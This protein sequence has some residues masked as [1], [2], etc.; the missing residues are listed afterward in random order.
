PVDP[1][2]HL[3]PGK[4]QV[5]EA[6]GDV[7]RHRLPDELVVRLGKQHPDPAAETIPVFAG[8]PFAADED[9]AFGGGQKTG[10]QADE[11]RFARPVPAGEAQPF[12]AFHAQGHAADGRRRGAGTAAGDAAQF[13]NGRTFVCEF[14]HFP[15]RPKSP[16][17]RNSPMRVSVPIRWRAARPTNTPVTTP[18]ARRTG[19]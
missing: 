9:V 2:V 4:A 11:R 10:H 7:V 5:F 1:A 17:S 15:S 6:E 19:K 18:A 14:F 8:E 3:F 13:E 12:T 16:I